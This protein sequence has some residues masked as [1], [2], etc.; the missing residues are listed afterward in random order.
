[1]NDEDVCGSSSVSWDIQEVDMVLR[2]GHDGIIAGCGE[3]GSF[4]VVPR[5][6]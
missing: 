3:A 4:D 5:E 1:M 6:R 2:D